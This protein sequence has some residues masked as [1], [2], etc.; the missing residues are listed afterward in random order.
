MVLATR[1][2]GEGTPAGLSFR[3]PPGRRA[4][5]VRVDEVTG[6]GGF[7]Q[8]GDRVDVLAVAEGV[9]PGTGRAVL[10]LEGIP[11]LAVNRDA[12]V[13]SGS[14][15]QGRPPEAFRYLT[16]AVT[17]DQALDLAVAQAFGRVHLLLRPA[18]DEERPAGRLERTTGILGR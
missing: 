15:A 8:P 16:L 2:A 14:S 1:L 7:I 3:I 13:P 11:V 5:A 18:A 9:A 17:P 12:E 10:L 6:A 4:M